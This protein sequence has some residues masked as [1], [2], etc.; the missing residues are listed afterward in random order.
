[1]TARAPSRT[2]PCNGEQAGQ[3]LRQAEAFL[4]W[5]CAA[6]AD[7]GDE[8]N[9]GVATSLAILAGVAATEALCGSSMGY[10]SRGQNHADAAI[11]I[12]SI[13]PRGA[14]L[15]STFRQLVTSKDDAPYASQA[16]RESS[17]KAAVR[18]AGDLVSAARTSL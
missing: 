6:L 3:R 13:E 12:R 11:L 8:V 16:M 5:A 7:D 14:D 17:A 1:M 18:R 9:L 2:T 15:A 4:G 10:Y